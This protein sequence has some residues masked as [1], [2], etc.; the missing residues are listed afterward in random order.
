MTSFLGILGNSGRNNLQAYARRLPDRSN[1]SFSFPLPTGETRTVYLPMLENCDISENKKAK[2]QEYQLLGRNS[3]IYSYGGGT[4]RQFQLKF[5]ITLLHVLETL[6]KEP[7]EDKFKNNYFQKVF[8]ETPAEDIGFLDPT[9]GIEVEDKQ[10]KIKSLAQKNY[11]QYMTL[12]GKKN[13]QLSSFDKFLNKAGGL[14][15]V[16]DF[17]PDPSKQSN[18]ALEA[19]ELIMYWIN[20]VRVGCVNNATNTT[21]GPPIVRLTHGIMYNNV[22]C[23]M[24]N[25]SINIEQERGYDINTLL[26]RVINISMTLNEIRIGN[27][28][29]FKPLDDPDSADNNYGWEALFNEGTID[30]YTQDIPI[31]FEEIY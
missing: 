21:L 27:F 5:K 18:K 8:S 2:L 12:T 28:G 15:G 14:F 13:P 25:Y 22:P 17:V 10:I 16:E 7:I 9:T 6:R 23:V 4:S 30:P 1:L 31:T 20:L 19:V 3:T 24:E 29:T 26:G 11:D